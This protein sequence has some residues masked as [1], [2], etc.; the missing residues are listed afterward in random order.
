VLKN[1]NMKLKILI[2]IPLIILIIIIGCKKV[3]MVRLAS[4]VTGEPSNVLETS[5]HAEGEIID[6]GE[7]ESV[8]EYGF[9]LSYMNLPP[10]I[11]DK[12][13]PPFDPTSI[14]GDFSSNI[15][16]LAENKNYQMRTYVVEPSGT[17]A[18]GN[19]V[20]FKTLSSGISGEWLNYDNGT[21]HTGVGLTEGGTFDLAVRFPTQALAPFN[22]F[23][24][25]KIK[26][27]PK[28]GSPTKYY[29]TFWEGTNPPSLIHYE[30]VYPGNIDQWNEFLPTYNY[31]INSSYEF[32]AG[33]WVLDQPPDTYPAGVDAGPAITGVGDMYSSDNGE[34][35]EP[36]SV[37]NPDLDYNWNLQVYVTNQKGDEVQ[38][39]R[40]RDEVFRENVSSAINS[41]NEVVSGKNIK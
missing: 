32:W 19:I 26:F 12:A 34:T 11:D 22:G 1:F 33:I 30:Q 37:L 16:G 3:D 28:V 13:V 4:V 23:S 9:C 6:L 18:Y 7:A 25:T 14:L 21:N 5:V 36:L 39:V 17:I 38:I 15:S 31:I 10:T 35:W 40:K 24:V 2:S 41:N 27:F 8:Q 29:I 20:E